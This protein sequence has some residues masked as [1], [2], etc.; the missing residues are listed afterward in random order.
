MKSKIIAL[1]LALLF[2]CGLWLFVVTVEQPES[3]N[4][5]YD[6]PVIYQNDGE[7]LLKDRGLMIVS[8]SHIEAEKHPHQSAESE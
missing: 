2:S 7:A 4:T 5:Y 1:L 3:E 6:I 8:H